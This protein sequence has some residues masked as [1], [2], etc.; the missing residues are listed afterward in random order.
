MVATAARG[1]WHHPNGLADAVERFREVPVAAESLKAPVPHR[2][3]DLPRT[4][5]RGEQIGTGQDRS[6]FDPR[7]QHPPRV[8][9]SEAAKRPDPENV[10]SCWDWPLVEEDS[11]V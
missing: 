11:S 9:P 8:D 6:L 10:Q 3:R 4:H 7:S 2:G 1:G 5:A